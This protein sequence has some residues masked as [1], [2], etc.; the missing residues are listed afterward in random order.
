MPRLRVPAVLA[1]S[2]IAVIA[3]AEC[4][5]SDECHDQC[6][7]RIVFDA[8]VNDAGF[9]DASACAVPVDPNPQGECP[10]GCMLE[11]CFG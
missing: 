7:Q 4:K 2:V 6:V 1:V 5:P 3:A 8:A 9:A 10:P 11:S